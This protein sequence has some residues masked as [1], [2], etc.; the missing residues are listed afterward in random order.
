MVIIISIPNAAKMSNI[1]KTIELGT[2][3][4]KH[5]KAYIPSSLG[6]NLPGFAKLD[7]LLG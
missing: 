6:S 5:A 7:V 4:E 3:I 2:S 1:V